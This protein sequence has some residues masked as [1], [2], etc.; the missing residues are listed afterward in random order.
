ME[1]ST[2]R[3]TFTVGE[4]A[5]TCGKSARALRLYE[6]MGLLTPMGRTEGGYREYGP[7]AVVRLRWIS[8]L[9]EMGFQ[10]DDVRSLIDAVSKAETAGG[11]MDDVRHRYA[12]VLQRIDERVARLRGLRQEVAVS[13]SYL[14]ACRGC[15]QTAHLKCCCECDRHGEEKPPLLIAGMRC[16]SER[17]RLNREPRIP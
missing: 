10:L 9:C 8:D 13:L 11:A 16:E 5:S 2:T 15:E 3:G 12:E 6:E 1:M 14:E 17:F 4:L 7:E